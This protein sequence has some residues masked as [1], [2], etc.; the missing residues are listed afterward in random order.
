[1][2]FV[3]VAPLFLVAGLALGCAE[4]PY[5]GPAAYGPQGYYGPY[6]PPPY[7]YAMMTQPN[8]GWG[9][10]GPSSAAAHAV[11]YAYSRIGTPY[12]WGGNGP[13]CFDCSG[14]TRAAWMSAGRNIPRTSEAQLAHL[15]PIPME[16]VQPGDILWRPGH[17]GL[18]VGQGWVIAATHTGDIVRYQ[19]ASK[20]VRAVRP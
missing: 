19:P 3:R 7:P 2:S 10:A 13:R 1:M 17:V 15:T 9:L 20:F 8:V 14:L 4:Q 18:Y 5:R 11:A 12:C 6:A 16:A